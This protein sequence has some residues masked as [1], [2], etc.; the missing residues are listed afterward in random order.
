MKNVIPILV[1]FLYLFISIVLING[2]SD[3]LPCIT[4]NEH[5]ENH[6]IPDA[7]NEATDGKTDLP[8]LVKDLSEESNIFQFTF[9][10]D[11]KEYLYISTF[12]FCFIEISEPSMQVIPPPPKSRNNYTFSV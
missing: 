1:A 5:A 4:V 3:T 8:V 10:P 2:R 11:K 9:S 12:F 7:D 6:A